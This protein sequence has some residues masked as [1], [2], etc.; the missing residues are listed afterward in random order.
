MLFCGTIAAAF[1]WACRAQWRRLRERERA[2][3]EVEDALVQNAQSVIVSVHGIV[4]NL[5]A[6]DPMRQKVEQALERADKQLSED[7][8]RVQ[9]LRSQTGLDDEPAR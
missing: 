5:G 9:D 8:D 4:K 1:A 2:A 6:D 3:R 7:R